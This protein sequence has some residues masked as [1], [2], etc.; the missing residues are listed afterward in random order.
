MRSWLAK[1]KLV[2]QWRRVKLFLLAALI[3]TL[4]LNLFYKTATDT[5]Y[6]QGLFVDYL[7]PKFYL[8]NFFALA[9][10]L[11][12]LF[13]YKS[14]ET[15]AAQKVFPWLLLALSL[16]LVC[17][18]FF[19][20]HPVASLFYLGQLALAL[21]L[22]FYLQKDPLWRTGPAKQVLVAALLGSLLLQ[23]FLG[24]YQFIQQAPLLPY[25][26]LGESNLLNFA[27][28]SRAV[29]WGEERI[30]AY[31]S[32]AHPNILAG[33]VVLFSILVRNNSHWLKIGPSKQRILSAL[34]L[35]NAL[36]IVLITQSLTA[37][38][39]LVLY[40]L[41]L[42]LRR[43]EK[44]WQLYTIII[45][46]YLFFLL[47]LPLALSQVNNSTPSV[48]RRNWLN[49]SALQIFLSQ[50]LVGVGLNNFTIPAASISQNKE[51]VRFAQPVHHL[52]LLILAEGGLL[53]AAW[54]W[55][56]LKQSKIAGLALKGLPLL[57]IAA[58]DHYLLTQAV[59]INL[60]L[61]F[62]TFFD[63]KAR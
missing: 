60:L 30:L 26:F 22:F 15:K 43:L 28:I 54:W 47:F 6:V 39:T 53:Y 12:E 10:L 38:M 51:I 33:L 49:Q 13:S 59:G 42:L 25:R 44:R 56:F 45:A 31:G 40:L 27:G 36:G 50:P 7:V 5:A 29:L 11:L 9:L 46:L 52:L 8:F 34:L 14:I 19:S 62:L 20:P 18:Q 37:A 63:T 57:A 16:L 61:L 58:L 23:S 32:T 2:L 41:Y 3:L 17:R 24:Y 4:P 48:S 55:Q 1:L 35:L 21:C